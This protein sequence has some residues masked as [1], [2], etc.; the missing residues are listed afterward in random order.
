[1]PI[2]RLCRY[3]PKCADRRRLDASDEK[4][5]NSAILTQ[6]RGHFL[7]SLFSHKKVAYSAYSAIVM[8]KEFCS[9]VKI[10]EKGGDSE[11][12]DVPGPG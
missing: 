11:N 6:F 4:I 10:F 1:M 9:K 2:G 5:K 12:G 3:E 7:F 8:A